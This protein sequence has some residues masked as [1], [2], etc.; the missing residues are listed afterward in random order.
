MIKRFLAACIFAPTFAPTFALGV[1]NPEHING[2]YFVSYRIPPQEMSSQTNEQA[3][4]FYVHFESDEVY[5]SLSKCINNQKP[6]PNLPEP[7]LALIRPETLTRLF[8]SDFAS[9]GQAYFSPRSPFVREFK[10]MHSLNNCVGIMVQSPIESKPY[11]FMHIDEENFLNGKFLRFLDKFSPEHRQGSLVFV[12]TAYRSPLLRDVLDTLES[13]GMPATHGILG[14]TLFDGSAFHIPASALN[15]SVRQI[16]RHSLEELG[17]KIPSSSY[18]MIMDPA[19][20][21]FFKIEFHDPKDNEKPLSGSFFLE[22]LQRSAF[23]TPQQA[24]GVRSRE[25]DPRA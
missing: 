22:D 18:Y 4:G 15:M 17:P 5:G 25:T 24:P 3:P 8:K 23:G 13:Q 10:I 7:L 11:G 1:T 6:W 14:D 16:A 9:Q 2:A 19:D 21:R 12:S 20:S